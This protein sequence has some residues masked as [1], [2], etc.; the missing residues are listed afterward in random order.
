MYGANVAILHSVTDG[1]F[2]S[3][4]PT[5]INNMAN[6]S[7]PLSFNAKDYLLNTEMEKIFPTKVNCQFGLH[8]KFDAGTS[9]YEFKI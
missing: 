1:H 8:N 2:I 6:T 3:L 7:S 9:K 4:L 5:I